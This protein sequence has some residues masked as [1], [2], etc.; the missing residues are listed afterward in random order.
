MAQV[1]ISSGISIL[2]ILVYVSWEALWLY[3]QLSTLKLKT[4]SHNLKKKIISFN[5]KYWNYGKYIEGGIAE[6]VLL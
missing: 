1:T 4:F 5:V 6:H 3:E 2:D